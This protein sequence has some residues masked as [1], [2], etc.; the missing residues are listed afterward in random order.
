MQE[1]VH[2]GEM[3]VESLG[4][5]VRAH[6][7]AVALSPTALAQRAG[8]TPSYCRAIERGCKTPSTRVVQ[9]LAAALD[10]APADLFGVPGGPAIQGPRSPGRRALVAQLLETATVLDEA[11]LRSLADYAGYLVQRRTSARPPRPV[12]API[13]L[14]P[15]GESGASE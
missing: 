10:C 13:P 7:L 14:F 6:R 4:V 11:A 3:S 15:E 8:I 2:P 9:R 5:N 12:A 1:A